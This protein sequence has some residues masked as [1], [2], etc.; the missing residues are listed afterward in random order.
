MGEAHVRQSNLPGSGGL[1]ARGGPPGSEGRVV[2]DGGGI[3]LG[4]GEQFAAAEPAYGG[5]DGTF[6]NA[7]IFGEF[8][9]ADLNG[10][11][12]AGLLGG[13]PKIHEKA[14][15]AAIVAHEI[16]QKHVG[17]VVVEHR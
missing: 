15:G 4:G 3:F 7:D 17:D 5:L 16:A 1:G 2:W 12:A 13:E 10:S 6:R 8:L 14:D 11:A 9:V